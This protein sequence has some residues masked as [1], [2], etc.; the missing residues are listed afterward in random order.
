[1]RGFALV[2]LCGCNSV[3]GLAQ[4][5]V[6]PTALRPDADPRTDLDLDGIKDVEDTC[7]APETDG[8]VDTDLDKITNGVDPCPLD[9]AFSTDTDADGLLDGCDPF[10]SVPGDRL[11]CLN[12]LTDPDLNVTMWRPRETAAEVSWKRFNPRAL[13]GYGGSIVADWP[14]EAPVTTTY[15]VYGRFDSSVGG[16][17]KVF[18]RAAPIPDPGDAGC[19]LTTAAMTWALGVAPAG[20]SGI[21]PFP[22]PFGVTQPFH[23]RITLV[24]NGTQYN[25]RCTGRFGNTSI[26][27]YATM[28]LPPGF[29]GIETTTAVTILSIA[30]YE[31]DDAAEF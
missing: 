20:T 5:E 24:P 29:V 27:A 26:S 3:L 17:F 19:M 7:I 21:I 18:A 2:A 11:R 6:P 23:M 22:A 4:T 8:L 31:R 1:M 14:F 12:A 16:T 9:G 13:F 30:T 28:A 10:I 15:D 25:V